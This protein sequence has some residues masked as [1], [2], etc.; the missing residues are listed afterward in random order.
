MTPRTPP[1]AGLARRSPPQADYCHPCRIVCTPSL[2]R[3]CRFPDVRCVHGLVAPRRAFG[4]CIDR[5]CMRRSALPARWCG[6]LVMIFGF[7][8]PPLGREDFATQCVLAMIDIVHFVSS[9]MSLEVSCGISTGRSFCGTIGGVHRKVH[10]QTS[11]P[12]SKQTNRQASKGT[13][14][15]TC[16]SDNPPDR[17]A[18]K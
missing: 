7:N 8:L 15:Q 18:I 9:V 2:A 12:I 3:V 4:V 10:S 11:D 1:A 5:A 17:E 14:T 13:D 16:N 6:R